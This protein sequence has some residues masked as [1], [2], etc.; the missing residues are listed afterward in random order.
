M[1]VCI[2]QP[3]TTVRLDKAITATISKVCI[4]GKHLGVTY[5]VVWWSGNERKEQWVQEYEI[6][7]PDEGSLPIGFHGFSRGFI[8]T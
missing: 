4:E 2:Y 7:S 3:G 1:S 6:E 5:C 8:P